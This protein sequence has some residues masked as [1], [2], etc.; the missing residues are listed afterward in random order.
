MLRKQFS[1]RFMKTLYTEFC[2]ILNPGD[3]V[4]NNYFLSAVNCT[5]GFMALKEKTGS[6]DTLHKL[7]V[8]EIFAL[9]GNQLISEE[10]N[11]FN[12][13]T[14]NQSYQPDQF[15]ALYTEE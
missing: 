7:L 13:S 1:F 15:H 12:I 10:K 6:L 8:I 4:C 5:V 3:E 2:S 9:I 14:I 11:L